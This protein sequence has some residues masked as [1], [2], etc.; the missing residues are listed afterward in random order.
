LVK[1]GKLEFDAERLE[2]LCRRWNIAKLEVFGSV[3][4]EDFGP[5]SDVDLLVSYWPNGAPKS[6][7]D[8]VRLESEL[9]EAVGRKVDL[10]SRERLLQSKNYIRK[11]H[12]LHSAE[13][14]YAA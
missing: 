6:Y 5:E 14:L 9:G 11:S 13:L 12:I 2:A 7:D 3:L 4:R 10:V 8:L 1:V